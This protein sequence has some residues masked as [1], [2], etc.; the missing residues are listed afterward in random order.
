M[1]YSESCT[2]AVRNRKSTGM[3]TGL[4]SKKPHS[5]YRIQGRNLAYDKLIARSETVWHRSGIS[6]PPDLSAFGT[7]RAVHQTW[8]VSTLNWSSISPQ[9]YSMI[10]SACM[11]KDMLRRF[12]SLKH[13]YR[14]FEQ[15]KSKR[16]WVNISLG[17]TECSRGVH[18]V[19]ED[20]RQTR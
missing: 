12:R 19:V 20:G 13:R 6:R 5:T 14:S 16:P 17:I 3:L 1:F 2:D 15:I 11:I 7:R 4:K 9:N 8:Y 18:P 10:V